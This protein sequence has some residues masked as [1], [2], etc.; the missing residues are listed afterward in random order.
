MRLSDKF[1]RVRLKDKLTEEEMNTF[2]VMLFIGLAIA[3]VAGIF[4]EKYMGEIMKLG[5]YIGEIAN[6]I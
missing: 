6:L 3:Y 5:K 1:A 4:V 2:T